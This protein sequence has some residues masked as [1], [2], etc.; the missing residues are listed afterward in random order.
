MSKDTN[1]VTN[2]ATEISTKLSEMHGLSK[3]DAAAYTKSVFE[4]MASMIKDSNIGDDLKLYGI[5]VITTK[6]TKPGVRRNPKTQ[7]TVNVEAKRVAKFR[8]LPKFK[9]ALNG[10]E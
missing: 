8:V 10:V 6:M 4:I 1:K 3:K 7:E 9:N 5:G 2:T